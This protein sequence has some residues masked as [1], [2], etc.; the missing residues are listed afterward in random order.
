MS[1]DE[2]LPFKKRN[3]VRESGDL[4]LG[5]GDLHLGSGD[6]HLGS[7]DEPGEPGDSSYREL[8]KMVLYCSVMK[9]RNGQAEEA[10]KSAARIYI[11]TIN[12]LKDTDLIL[13]SCSNHAVIGVV[14]R[15]GSIASLTRP[16][17]STHES[18]GCLIEIKY[19]MPCQKLDRM[20]DLF[21]AVREILFVP[22]TF[23]YHYSF[24][25]SA[26]SR[27]EFASRFAKGVELYAKNSR[28]LKMQDFDLPSLVIDL[29]LEIKR[30]F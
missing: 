2:T 19:P 5:S 16:Y 21:K 10:F 28:S 14:Q 29:D 25:R 26:E 24:S 3:H 23:E 13:T 22:S 7:G 27:A 8:A 9:R 30:M 18:A 1:K 12:G 4:H 11:N 20:N 6:L 17:D 15:N